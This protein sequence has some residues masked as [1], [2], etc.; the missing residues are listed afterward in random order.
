MDYGDGLYEGD[1]Q[2]ITKYSKALMCAEISRAMA[3]SN[4]NDTS[5]DPNILSNCFTCE[6]MT[7]VCFG[8]EPT[9]N[10][11]CLCSCPS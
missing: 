4:P 8:F 7:L 6:Y 11:S 2:F 5:A 3:D 9:I 1:Y 10:C